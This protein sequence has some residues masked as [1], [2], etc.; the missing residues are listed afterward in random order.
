MVTWNDFAE[1]HYLS[2]L[3][4]SRT[5][6]CSC[7]NLVA[8][9]TH[10]DPGIAAAYVSNMPHDAWLAM[11]QPYIAAYKAGSKNETGFVQTEG[12]ASPRVDV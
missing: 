12:S 6:L 10:A 1:S 11:A 3:R 2:P 8:L 4:P 5:S 9:L 7:H